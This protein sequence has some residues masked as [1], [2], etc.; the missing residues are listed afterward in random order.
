[1]FAGEI[2]GVGVSGDVT[3]KNFEVIIK[4]YTK[5]TVDGKKDLW[6]VFLGDIS[7]VTTQRN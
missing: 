6:D 2:D 3:T 4:K 1:M 5:I 7:V